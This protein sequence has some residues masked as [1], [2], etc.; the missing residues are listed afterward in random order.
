MITNAHRGRVIFLVSLIT[1]GYVALGGRL[2]DI[3]VFQHK[4]HA[5]HAVDN[6]SRKVIHASRRGD[7]LDS[8]GTVLATSRIA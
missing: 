3:Q 4:K 6:T 1:A 7:I 5:A 2:G 8:R